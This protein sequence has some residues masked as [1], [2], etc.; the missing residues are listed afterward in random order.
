VFVH[1]ERVT[2]LD[3]GQTR[4]GF[5]GD[6]ITSQPINEYSNILH[7]NIRAC[8]KTTTLRVRADEKL[9]AFVELELAISRRAVLG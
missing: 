5:K 1:G 7:G 4:F 8:L 3:N 2:I 9:T 6:V